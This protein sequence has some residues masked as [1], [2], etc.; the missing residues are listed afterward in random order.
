MTVLYAEVPGFYAEV[1][2]SA[3]P[4]LAGRAVVVGGDPRKNGTVQS[5]SAEARAAGVAP[6]MAVLEALERCPR[7]K[8]LRTDMRRYREASARLRATLRRHLDRLE[9]AG[10]GA[11]YLD[12]SGAARPPEALAADLAKAVG[13]DLGLPLR[14]GIAS[15]KFLARLAAEEGEGP[16]VRVALGEEADFLAGLPL[17]RL[18]GVGPTT[19]ARLAELG[20]RSIAELA[21]L[22]RRRVELASA[23]TATRSGSWLTAATRRACSRATARASARSRASCPKSTIWLEFSTGFGAW[24]RA[25]RWPSRARSCAPGA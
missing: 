22:E 5:A 11:A 9:P 10:L 12:A 8:V 4:T 14:V 24:P 3:D 2:R 17:E 25:W 16:I 1:E 20:A 21:G 19:A 6:G 15:A 13:D 7:A 18:P 23:P